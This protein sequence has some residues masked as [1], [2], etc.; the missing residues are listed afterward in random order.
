MTAPIAI[1]GA[2]ISGASLAYRLTRRGHAVLIVDDGRPGRATGWNP[3][4]INP[5]HGPGFPGP[6]APIYHQAHRLHLDQ[7]A[8]VRALSDIDY[9]WRTIDRLFLAANA[10]EAASLQALAPHYEALD[11]FS[12]RWMDNGDIARW[13]ERVGPAWIGGLMTRGNARLDAERYRLA[14]IAAATRRGARLVN[15]RV[16]CVTGVGDRI[17]GIRWAEG[18]A[19]ISAL[20]MATGSWAEDRIA[21]WSPGATVMVTPLIGDLLLIKAA[22][23]PPLADVSHGLVALYQHDRDHYWLGG[24]ERTA[25]PLGDGGAAIRD[26]LIAGARRLMPGWRS[27]QIVAQSSAARPA[28]PDNRPVLGRTPAYRNGWVINGGGG[29]GMLL[30]AWMAKTLCRMIEKDEDLPEAAPFSPA[31]QMS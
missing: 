19:D 25:G 30:S 16:E 15:G 8:D 18:R 11:G 17:A 28:T 26:R 23:G 21:G 6:M 10:D 9:G 27:W 12:A 4:G 1:I 22:G 13:D 31:R 7:Q 29:K 5:L 20:C 2:G 3:G 24:T 14:L